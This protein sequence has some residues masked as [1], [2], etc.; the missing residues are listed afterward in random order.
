M[1]LGFTTGTLTGPSTFL[2]ISKPL[3]LQGVFQRAVKW[4]GKRAGDTA[5]PIDHNGQWVCINSFQ[6]WQVLLLQNTGCLHP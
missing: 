3:H 2:A 4:L 6:D 1:R 5:Q